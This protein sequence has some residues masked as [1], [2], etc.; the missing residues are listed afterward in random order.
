MN[1]EQIAG[2]PTPAD[3][4]T[5]KFFRDIEASGALPEGVSAPDA[6]S[7][8][9]C[10]LTMR[11]SGGEAREFVETTPPALKSLLEP[12]VKHRDE[13]PRKFD[14]D[15]FLLFVADHLGLGSDTQKAEKIA[16]AVFSAVRVDLPTREIDD[17]A[18]QLPR[19]LR[20]LWCFNTV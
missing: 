5:K 10:T 11:V 12:C 18:S 8:V 7:A 6:A 4:K 17:V 2:Q 14:R 13:R 19:D 15:Q 20:D 16:R 3:E 9:L 1:Q